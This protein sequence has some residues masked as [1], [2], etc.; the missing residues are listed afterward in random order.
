MI[1]NI[2]HLKP[3]HMSEEFVQINLIQ[4]III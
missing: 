3:S 2:S 4:I 1:N